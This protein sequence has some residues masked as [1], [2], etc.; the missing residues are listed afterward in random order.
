[1]N[2]VTGTEA[3]P[4]SETMVPD[5]PAHPSSRRAILNWQRPSPEWLELNYAVE[6]LR[7]SNRSSI[8]QFVGAGPKVGTTTVAC[9]FAKAAGQAVFES[10]T[11]AGSAARQP[12]L[13]IDCNDERG[14]FRRNKNKPFRSESLIEAYRRGATASSATTP[15][16]SAPGV[17]WTWLG[18]TESSGSIGFGPIDIA[19]LF[20]GLRQQF[21]LVVLD[22]PTVA[23]GIGALA[24][25]PH[26]DGTFVVL[27]AAKT[28]MAAVKGSRER[29]ERVGAQ[30][31]GTVFNRVPR[32]ASWFSRDGFA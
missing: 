16:A 30:V 12:V 24:L 11:L 17:F 23:Y 21:S 27:R 9:G 28:R 31:I 32:T 7:V 5:A 15:I 20:D 18:P 1:M 10:S 3:A 13:V 25:A 6:N 8:V 14:F 29:L 22:C 4:Y 2:A 19:R 26:C